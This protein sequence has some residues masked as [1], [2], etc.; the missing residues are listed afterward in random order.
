MSSN[1]HDNNPTRYEIVPAQKPESGKG[2]NGTES[3]TDVPAALLEYNIQAET[4]S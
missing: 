2:Q 3:F 4:L 1:K